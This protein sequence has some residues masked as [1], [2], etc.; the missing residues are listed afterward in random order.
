M[1]EK[2][3]SFTRVLELARAF[4]SHL[5]REHYSLMVLQGYASQLAWDVYMT[6]RHWHSYDGKC[7]KETPFEIYMQAVAIISSTWVADIYLRKARDRGAPQMEAEYDRWEKFIKDTLE[8]TRKEVK[9]NRD[10]E[11]EIGYRKVAKRPNRIRCWFNRWR[12]GH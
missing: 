7:M 10:P 4:N 1:N 12:W 11:A 6:G 2:E 3:T 5:S 9:E 8:F